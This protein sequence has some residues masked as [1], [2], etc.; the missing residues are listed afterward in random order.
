MS[1]EM[2]EKVVE[3][4]AKN[5]EELLESTYQD[6]VEAGRKYDY[7]V[8]S[9]KFIEQGRNEA[10]E[11]ARKIYLSVENGGLPA[12]EIK[13]IF[14][15]N[16]EYFSTILKKFSAS[17]A[18]K[19]LRDYEEKQEEPE[20]DEEI[21]VGDEVILNVT[22]SWDENTKAIIIA[23]EKTLMFPYNVMVSSGDTDWVDKNDIN[24]KTGRHF[25]E[26]VEA[27]KKLKEGK[28]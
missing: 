21:K 10:W 13:K 7:T 8:D 24:H 6:G 11:A 2:K 1:L 5:I 3:Q 17:E 27:L 14:G 9:D 19:K 15:I 25:P 4:I 16:Y 22:S 20:E 12:I 18:I 26:I 28:E 23:D